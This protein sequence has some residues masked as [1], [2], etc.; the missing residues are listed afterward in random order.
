[1]T[2]YNEK[3]GQPMEHALIVLEHTTPRHLEDLKEILV[4]ELG[5]WQD[6]LSD[7]PHNDQAGRRSAAVFYLLCD[8]EVPGYEAP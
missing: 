2:I 3:N 7:N 6:I 8:L 1:M 5:H 4:E